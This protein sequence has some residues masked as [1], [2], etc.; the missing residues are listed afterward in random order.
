MIRFLC[1]ILLAVC[2]LACTQKQVAVDYDKLDAGAKRLPQ[3]AVFSMDVPDGI[4][5]GFGSAKR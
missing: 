5:A 2:A 1:S 3:N 4:E